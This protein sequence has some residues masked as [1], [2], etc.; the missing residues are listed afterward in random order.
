MRI[1]NVVTLLGALIAV[2]V[3]F[4][5]ADGVYLGPRW[6]KEGTIESVVPDHTVTVSTYEW[7]RLTGDGHIYLYTFVFPDGSSELKVGDQTRVYHDFDGYF[8]RIGA[9]KIRSSRTVIEY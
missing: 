6:G 3:F 9:D 4:Y 8:L 5:I 7:T 1:K 2:W